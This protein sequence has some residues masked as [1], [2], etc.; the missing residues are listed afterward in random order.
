MALA[1][2][3]KV[4]FQTYL[5]IIISISISIALYFYIGFVKKYKK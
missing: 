4:Q 3:H 5:K 2:S 1:S